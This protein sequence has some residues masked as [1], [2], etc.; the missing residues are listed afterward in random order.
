[1]ARCRSSACGNVRLHGGNADLFP[2]GVVS[3]NN[4]IVTLLIFL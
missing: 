4:I 3:A 1:M 2:L